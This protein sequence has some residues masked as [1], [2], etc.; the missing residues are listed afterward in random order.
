MVGKYLSEVLPKLQ[1]QVL[2]VE[3][4]VEFK[5]RKY[6][7]KQR[8]DKTTFR[9]VATYN[10]EDRKY[11]AYLTD[12]PPDTL[13]A[14]DIATLYS[15]RWDVELI[16]KELKSR[17]ALDMIDTTNPQIVE[18][19]IWIAILTLLVSRRIYTLVRDSSDPE[20]IVRYTQ[21]RWSTIFAENA[22]DQLTLILRYNGIQRTFDTV[23]SVYQSQALD[24]HVNRKRLMDPWRA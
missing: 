18:A 21:L 16:F 15:A 4:E 20:K 2:D 9:L 3:V 13:T 19:Y 24:P 8:K 1:R 6:K 5:R 12:I 17:Y 11:H 23:M 10:A 22:S 14:E 7:N